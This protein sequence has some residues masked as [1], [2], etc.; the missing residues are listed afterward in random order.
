MRDQVFISY[1][2]ADTGGIAGRLEDQLRRRYSTFR[3]VSVIE[4]G[5]NYERRLSDA[6]HRC[7]VM[8]VLIGPAWMDSRRWTRNVSKITRHA[9]GLAHIERAP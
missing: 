2:R 5:E 6:M 1:R 8:L 7:R 3:D 9:S 4:Y